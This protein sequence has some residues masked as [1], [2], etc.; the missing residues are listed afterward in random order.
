MP[1]FL[2]WLDLKKDAMEMIERHGEIWKGG[3][4][5]FAGEGKSKTR[6]N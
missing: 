3:A 6:I 1:V 5:M 4:V 2:L